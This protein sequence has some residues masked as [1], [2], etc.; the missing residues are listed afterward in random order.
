M[1]TELTP[2]PHQQIQVRFL[3]LNLPQGAPPIFTFIYDPTVLTLPNTGGAEA[4]T[5]MVT[6]N[7]SSNIPGAVL[8]AENTVSGG[9]PGMTSSGSGTTALTLTFT[10]EGMKST[11]SFNYT[12]SVLANNQSYTSDDPEIVIPPPT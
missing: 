11:D 7:L 12:L 3:Q 5:Y 8:T 1:P 2:A 6:F 4:T 9:P 10:N